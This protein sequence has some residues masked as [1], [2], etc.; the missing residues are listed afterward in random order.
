MISVAAHAVGGIVDASKPGA[1]VL[2]PVTKL[3][4]FSETVAIAVAKEAGKEGLN[5]NDVSDPEACI[6]SYKWE[7]AYK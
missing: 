5:R 4:Q 6:K 2:P 3:D 1:S 7:P